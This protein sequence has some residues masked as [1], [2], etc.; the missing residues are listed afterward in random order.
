MSDRGRGRNHGGGRPPRGRGKDQ[1]RETFIQEIIAKAE[2]DQPP[3]TG[4]STPSQI[5][6]RGGSR[7]RSRGKSVNQPKPSSTTESGFEEEEVESKKT[8]EEYT[9]GLEEEF[10]SP[11]DQGSVAKPGGIFW[12]SNSPLG[13]GNP[14]QTEEDFGESSHQDN[15]EEHLHSEGQGSTDKQTQ[16]PSGNSAKTQ[17]K[18]KSMANSSLEFPIG[19]ITGEAPMKSIP[20]SALPNFHG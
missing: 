2:S 17:S 5:A 4:S 13:Q 12:E 18:Y 10:V 6:G 3:R 9:L 14:V 15:L 19:D 20:F 8:G 16:T 11:R 7:L 1:G